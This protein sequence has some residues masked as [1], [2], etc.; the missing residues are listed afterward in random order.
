[1]FIKY[2]QLQISAAPV[3]MTRVLKVELRPQGDRVKGCV[4][5]N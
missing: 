4:P 5:G 1:M 3:R 2:T